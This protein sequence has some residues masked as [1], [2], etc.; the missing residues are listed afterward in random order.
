VTPAGAVVELSWVACLVLILLVPLALAGMALMNTGLG[1]ARSASHSMLASLVAIA[2]AA[3]VYCAC[4]YSLE[5]FAG[6]SAHTF[7]V[8]GKSWNWV[9]KEPWLWRG[10]PG[11]GLQPTLAALLQIFGVGLAAL[12]PL[13]TGADRWRLSAICISTVLLAGWTYPFFAH[14]V[15]GGG[16]LSQLGI[17]YGL[18]FGF[19][20]PGGAST[21]HGVGGLSALAIAWILKP[22]R[23]KYAQD[24]IAAAIPGHNIVCVLL[25]CVLMLPGWV[26]LSSAGAILFAGTSAAQIPLIAVNTILSASAACLM[27]LGFTRIR[28]GKPDASICANGWV[29]GLVTSSALSAF[30]SPAAAIVTGSVAGVLV[31]IAVELLELHLGV[32]D[33]GGAISV[34]AVAALWGLLAFGLFAQLPHQPLLTLRGSSQTGQLLAQVV[35]IATLLGVILPMTYGLNWLL[36][37]AHPQRVEAEGERLGMDLYELGAGAYPEFVAHPDEFL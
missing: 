13:S 6:G 19:L 31:I 25:G 36:N 14:W 7:L 29:A 4:G 30:V 15:W 8:A 34:H 3:I 21:I 5:G 1:R 24:G 37:R 11:G 20:D 18:G 22:R 16:W 17:T 12:I 35:G 10:L 26:G 32:D 27:A 9:A 28:F 2:I 33:P 23:G